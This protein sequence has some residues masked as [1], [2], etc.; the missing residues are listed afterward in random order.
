MELKEITSFEKLKVIHEATTKD[1]ETMTVKARVADTKRNANNRSY[2]ASL[3]KREVARLQKQIES[4]GFFG[5]AEHPA[6]G[7]QM[8]TG[9]SHIFKKMWFEP[10]TEEVWA[11]LKIIPT[12]RGKDL[13]TLIKNG[14]QLG[15]STR[16]TGSVSSEGR[17]MDDYKMKGVDIVGSPSS[18]GATFDKDAIFESLNLEPEK[19][20]DEKMRHKAELI[21]AH[22]QKAIDEAGGT[23]KEE[24]TMA[25][26]T[27]LEEEI[28]A[29]MIIYFH[30]ARKK[31]G[32]TGTIEEWKATDKNEAITRAALEFNAGKYN[33][34]QEA[35]IANDA[36]EI[37]EKHTIE[38]NEI[39]PQ[40]YAWEAREAGISPIE[41]A[42]RLNA[43]IA[44]TVQIAAIKNPIGHDQTII[45]EACAAGMDT[46]TPEKRLEILR[47]SKQVVIKET[48][49]DTL[50][51]AQAVKIHAQL[52]ESGEEVSLD[53]VRAGLLKE[54]EKKEAE[55]AKQGR[56]QTYVRENLIAGPAKKF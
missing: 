36:S 7:N 44:E 3:L 43:C 42:K 5:T 51:E 46:S 6:S 12:T 45:A 19:T 30:E 28:R 23:K 56:I 38:M 8:V 49:E 41:Y 15:L 10:V 2:P 20:E 14:A 25:K 9:A 18:Q 13:M 22:H 53:T 27:P 21:N 35:L 4:G 24:K 50:L 29:A 55:A 16:G 39:D 48:D 11:E 32:F 52:N 40:Q 54:R 33:T 37:A 26:R 47:K 34:I 31:E 1:G 17:V